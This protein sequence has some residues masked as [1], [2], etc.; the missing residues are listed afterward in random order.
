MKTAITNTLKM[1][2]GLIP[3]IIQDANTQQ[4]LML[5]Y[6]N[7]E[8]LARSLAEKRVWFYSRSKQRLWMKGETSGN[9]LELV[10]CKADC[11][12]DAL[13]IRV[14]PLGPVC[15]KGTDTCWGETNRGHFLY[16]LEQTIQERKRM[17]QEGSYTS[18]LF[19]KGINK[20]GQKVGEEAVE[21][22]ID[23][24]NGTRKN[25][26]YEAADLMY[27]YLVLLAAKDCALEDV[28]EE[29][30]GRERVCV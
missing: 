4:V 1:Q 7:A 25:F 11:D 18:S 20:I 28:M 21:M 9:V 10:D 2:D 6:M 13:L 26:L 12:K 17:P 15:H 23:G 19:G 16:E 29:L 5:G 24:I 8:S 3:A 14:K 27:H 30:K 22:L